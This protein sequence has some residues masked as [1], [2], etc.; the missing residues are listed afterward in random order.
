MIVLPGANEKAIDIYVAEHCQI[1]ILVTDK[2]EW[3]DITFH[4]KYRGGTDAEPIGYLASIWALVLGLV[5][6]PPLQTLNSLWVR[7]RSLLLLRP[8]LPSSPRALEQAETFNAEVEGHLLEVPHHQSEERLI[9]RGM[10]RELR[11]PSLEVTISALRTW[12]AAADTVAMRYQKHVGKMMVGLVLL[13]ALS[14]WWLQVALWPPQDGRV[15]G[16]RLLAGVLPAC[17]ILVVWWIGRWRWRQVA[18]RALAESLRVRVFCRLA[19]LPREEIPTES[20]EWDIRN[21]TH[22]PPGLAQLGASRRTGHRSS[23]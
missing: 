23:R 14:L 10:L 13:A 7:L 19:G 5:E 1:H 21:P 12:Y 17:V 18:H 6:T 4:S 3:P 9:P 16:D 15:W 11:S 20:L 8:A 22:C 2:E